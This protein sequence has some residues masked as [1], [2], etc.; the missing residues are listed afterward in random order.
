MYFEH[1]SNYSHKQRIIQYV[2]CYWTFLLNQ[3]GPELKLILVAN[4]HFAWNTKQNCQ[5]STCYNL[6][7]ESINEKGFATLK[8]WLAKKSNRKTKYV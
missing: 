3:V 2:H 6:R 4:P 5:N 7:S 8:Y 1:L